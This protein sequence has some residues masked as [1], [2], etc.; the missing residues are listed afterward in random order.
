MSR[1]AGLPI[2]DRTGAVPRSSQIFLQ[3]EGNSPCLYTVGSIMTFLWA[4]LLWR[5]A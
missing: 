2:H 1:K 3:A 4:S 5:H